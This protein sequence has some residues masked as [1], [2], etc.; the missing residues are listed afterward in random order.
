MFCQQHFSSCLQVMCSKSKFR[1]SR[2]YILNRIHQDINVIAVNCGRFGHQLT[3]E[4]IVSVRRP[5][6]SYTVLELIY[7]YFYS[8]YDTLSPWS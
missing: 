1:C 7:V 2:G 3:G 4:Y 6:I 5:Q 8:V